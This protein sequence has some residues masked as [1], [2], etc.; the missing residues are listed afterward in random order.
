[1]HGVDGRRSSLT[2]EGQFVFN[3][4][5]AQSIYSKIRV[6]TE[7]T[8]DARRIA[9]SRSLTRVR[10]KPSPYIQRTEST[11]CVQK[12][13]RR[14]SFTPDPARARHRTVTVLRSTQRVVPSQR[15]MALRG[16]VPCMPDPVWKKHS[17]L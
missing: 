6:V 16:A 11:T 2:G 7:R 12:Y 3:T 14:G 10:T 5:E 8:A 9:C 13:E 17:P 1:M 15:Q 4:T